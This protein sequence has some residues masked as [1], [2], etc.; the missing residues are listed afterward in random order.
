MTT[1]QGKKKKKSYLQFEVLDEQELQILP[2][3]FLD[4]HVILQ[5]KMSSDLRDPQLEIRDCPPIVIN[6]S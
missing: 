6:E 2:T 1:I 4:P 3:Y 5:V